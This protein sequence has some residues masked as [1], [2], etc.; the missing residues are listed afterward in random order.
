MRLH[1][2]HLA[3]GAA[4]IIVLMLTWFVGP[5]FHVSGTNAL[6]LR[7]GILLLGVIAIIALLLWAR[8]NRPAIP[9]PQSF[10][11]P[12][13]PTAS[14]SASMAASALA[15]ASSA[16]G[17][18]GAVVQ[19]VDILVREASTK[20]AA[21]RLAA[22]AT[23]SA[24]PAV[25]LLGESGAGKTSAMDQSGLDAELLAGQV[26]QESSVV[27]T[28]A[29]NL[30]FARKTVFVEAGGPLLEDPA[31]WVRLVK[32]FVPGSMS[33]V[34]GGSSQAPRAAIVC[35]D[36]EK[37]VREAALDKIVAQARNLRA[38]LEEL[39]YHLGVS[40]PVYVLF[41]R[42][43]RV[44]YFEEFAG[45]FSNE[46]TSQVLGTTLP[47]SAS[48]AS[49]VY[50]EQETRRLTSAFQG[51]FF[52]LAECRPGLLS[53]ERNPERQAGVYEFPREFGKLSKPLVQF[54]VDLCRPGHLRTGPFLRGFYFVGQRVIS[55][56][57]SSGQ[58]AIGPRASLQRAPGAFN[59]AATSL[60]NAEDPS[61]KAA[62]AT[63]TS[64]ESAGESRKSL[65][66]VF[67][68]H[69]F[70]HIILQDRA[71]LGA[72]GKSTRGDFGRRILFASLGFL[73]LLWIIFTLISF[74]GNQSIVSSIKSAGQDLSLVQSPGSQPPPLDSLRR[75]DALRQTLVQ[76]R[77]YDQNGAPLHLRWGLYSGDSVFDDAR[78]IYFHAFDQLL[79]QHARRNLLT[80][81][82]SYQGDP[83]ASADS[84]SA[85]DALKTYLLTTSESQRNSGEFLQDFLLQ[86]WKKDLGDLDPDR[87]TLAAQ[88]FAFYSSELTLDNPFSKE[89]DA[90]L[91]LQ[92]RTYL[93]KLAGPQRIYLSML[94][95]ARQ[96]AKD[97]RFAAQH[98][99]SLDVL[100]APV[101]VSAA[102]TS[103][104]WKVMDADIQNSK[105]FLQ[106]EPWVLGSTTSV[107]LSAADLMQSLRNL[108]DK[109]YIKQWRSFLS[110]ARVL[111]YATDSDAATKLGKLSAN[112]S[113]LL[114][115]ICDVS[116]NTNVS[117]PAVKLA[118][119]AP[120]QVVSP[121]CGLQKKYDQ[122]SNDQYMKGL[123][124]LQQCVQ[125]AA[126]AP[127]DQKEASKTSC[128]QTATQA[129]LSAA[130]I[131]QGLPNDT[132]G[133][134]DQ[135]VG[136][137]LE[138]PIKDLQRLWAGGGG[139]SAEGL[140]KSFRALQTAYPFNGR[141]SREISLPE[142]NA[143]FQPAK[144]QLSQYLAG[145]KSTLSLQGTTW[146]R[147]LDT[148][149]PVG[150]RY[151]RFINALYAIQVAVYPNGASDP[152]FEYSVSARLPDA[153]G[154]K[155]EKLAFDGQEWTITGGGGTKR[156]TWPGAVVQG[157]TLSLNSGGGDLELQRA[158]GL[159][160]VAHFFGGY[161]WQP[162]GN[163]YIIQGPLHGPTGQPIMSNNKPV[164]VR[165]DVDLKGVPFFQ[166]GYMDGLSCPAKI[167]Q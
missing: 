157:A 20:V 164:E 47:L 7:G 123:L 86:E 128:L 139:G 32:H 89:N 76:L 75:L 12:S 16:S 132:E 97:Y 66:R 148:T 44:P 61:A 103:E 158:S 111:P 145:Q 5:I 64:L 72:S 108:Y 165:F 38:R 122:S 162:S 79:F 85:Y 40:L 141:T 166:E 21:A 116:D 49:G 136:N 155:S 118:F 22:G 42:S 25:F 142:F 98:P 30:W 112:F 78:A 81:L 70:S 26:Y 101:D 27:P 8:S 92:V 4:A 23:L 73:A 149:T 11:T 37:L 91:V 3:A 29:A 58:T 13:I 74:S 152:R 54:L 110:S 2:E 105:R 94:A 80:D 130:Q 147:S 65:Q 1:W 117:S 14:S 163:G 71:A 48:T 96:K 90:S 109:D 140:C 126:D 134:V 131:A 133:H 55:V 50:A 120:Q 34:F 88:Q 9:L 33:S 121:G 19:D 153:G 144:G 93:N 135:T 24:L 77:G 99:D 83:Q 107:D 100:R 114:A 160:A 159:W 154:F 35:V 18:G 31:S 69:V 151:L 156:F 150:P 67:L 46:E 10:Q 119:Q 68:S 102:F 82:H 138:E 15:S 167:N 95:D 45:T 113:P 63:G 146:V 52:A 57:G 17:G 84:G 106:G 62:W 56:S 124:N 137:L 104:G 6:V 60:L 43:D 36:C 161:K 125:Q 143:F 41:N 53:R 127:P 115:L 39:S 59:P 51:M 28:R 87:S 129:S